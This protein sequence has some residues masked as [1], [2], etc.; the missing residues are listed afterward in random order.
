METEEK[1]LKREEHGGCQHG[2]PGYQTGH[3]KSTANVFFGKRP[4]I[5]VHVIIVQDMGEVIVNKGWDYHLK[6]KIFM[7]MK[8]GRAEGGGGLGLVI[9]YSV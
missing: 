2:C 4:L 8:S 9:K 3:W 5:S 7:L 6:I 1:F